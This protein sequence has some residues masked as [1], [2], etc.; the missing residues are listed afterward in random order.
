[1]PAQALLAL[2]TPVARTPCHNARAL[3][4]QTVPDA[5][6]HDDRIGT[7]QKAIR[8]LLSRHR[9]ALVHGLLDPAAMIGSS[10]RLVCGAARGGDSSKYGFM[11]SDDVMERVRALRRKGCTPKQIARALHLPP[12]TGRVTGQGD[13]SGGGRWRGLARADAD[14]GRRLNRKVGRDGFHYI[15][16]A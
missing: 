1:M 11:A 13:C 4:V 14:S 9:E 16:P 15:V 3:C 10:R 6:E 2:A 5:G 8:K 12:A 7:D